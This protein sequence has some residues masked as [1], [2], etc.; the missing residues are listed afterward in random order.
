VRLAAHTSPIFWPAAP[1]L[2]FEVDI[3][4]EAECDIQITLPLPKW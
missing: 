3:L 4:D 2:P 1:G